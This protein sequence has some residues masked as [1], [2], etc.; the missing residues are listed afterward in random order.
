MNLAT[1]LVL[2]LISITIGFLIGALVYGLRAKSTAQPAPQEKDTASSEQGV[3]LWR[4]PQTQGISVE[5]EGK[6]YHQVGELSSETRNRLAQLARDWQL[7]LGMPLSRLAALAAQ[8]S[9][10]QADPAQSANKTGIPPETAP[11][12]PRDKAPAGTARVTEKTKVDT[13]PESIAAQIDAILQVRLENSPLAERQIKLQELPGQGLVV[14]VGQEKYTDLTLV[15]DQQVR[16]A[17]AA[18]VTEWEQKNAP[19]T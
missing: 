18:A 6:T 15:P 5:L 7:W 19:W 8:T 9:P 13:A 11:Q 12:A 1:T 17:I 3:R 4:D 10:G 2:I 16:E 14:I